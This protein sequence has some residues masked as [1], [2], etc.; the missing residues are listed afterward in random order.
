MV[1]GLLVI[2]CA[3]VLL[4]LYWAVASSL[5]PSHEIFAA[6]SPLWPHAMTLEHYAR[7]FTTTPVLRWLVN[8]VLVAALTTAAGIVVCTLAGFGFAK[9]EFRG[10]DAVFW[11][12]L[13]SVTIPQAVTLVPVFAW[14]SRIGWLN[15]YAV[16]VVPRIANAFGMFL[17]RQYIRTVPDDLLDAARIDGCTDWAVLWHV[18]LPVV[19]PAIGALAIYLWLTSWNSYLWP[20]VMVS[21]SEMFTLPLGL[22]ALYANPYDRDYGMIMAGAMVS[23]LPILAVFLAMQ[24]QFIEGLTRGA[25]KG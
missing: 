24:R 13:A 19:R 7:L 12:I 4:P 11:A 25:I 21:S 5:K 22:A 6:R 9:Y 3:L 10:R 17:M 16:L 8:S 20:L 15:T 18:I 23:V 2:V 14:M 1:Y